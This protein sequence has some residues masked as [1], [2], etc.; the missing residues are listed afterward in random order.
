[1]PIPPRRCDDGVVAGTVATDSPAPRRFGPLVAAE[2]VPRSA[3]RILVG[4]AGGYA[5]HWRVE[6]TVVRAAI[7][8]LT[9]A[10]GIGAVL[11]GIGILTTAPAEPGTAV[12]AA[13]PV[14]R[15]RE[16]AIGAATLAILVIAR[17]ASL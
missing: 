7:G 13:A 16:L 10:G 11:Y 2:R 14:D 5:A 12:T 6:P 8:L 1:M 4:V 15:R 3:D 17:E 9:L